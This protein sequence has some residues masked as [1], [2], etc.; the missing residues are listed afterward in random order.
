MDC[1]RKRDVLKQERLFTQGKEFDAR[2]I[3]MF[4]LF[5]YECENIIFDVVCWTL[6]HLWK[7]N[8]NMEGTYEK[9]TGKSLSKEVS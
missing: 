3:I 9:N 1:F 4:F 8:K 6:D 2:L 7:N 5:C